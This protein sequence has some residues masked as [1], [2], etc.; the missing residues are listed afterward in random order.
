MS[1]NIIS[2]TLFIVHSRS[3]R[4][5]LY[6]QHVPI[7]ARESLC[8]RGCCTVTWCPLIPAWATTLHKFQG[9]EAGFDKTDMF[10]YLICDPGDRSWEQTCPGALYTALSRAKTMGRFTKSKRKFTRKSAIYWKGSGIRAHHSRIIEEW[11]EKG[12]SENKVRTHSQKRPMG[13][14]PQNTLPSHTFSRIQ[15]IKTR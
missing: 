5:M 1:A 6:L 12:R 4:K 2:H 9:F 15:Q 8:R 11:E 7:P 14:V 13:R 3:F 10:R